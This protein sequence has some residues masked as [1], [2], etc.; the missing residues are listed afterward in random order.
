MKRSVARISAER[1]ERLATAV[2]RVLER[3]IAQ[4]GTTLNDFVDGAG[5]S[6]YFQVSLQVY[7]RAGEPCTRCGKPIRRLVLSGRSTYFCPRCQR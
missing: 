1:W 7:D 4:G 2:R 6:G 5:N 3:A